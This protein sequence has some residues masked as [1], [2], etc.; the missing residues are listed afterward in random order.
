[1]SNSPIK[2]FLDSMKH[3]STYQ[4]QFIEMQMKSGQ[5]NSLGDFIERERE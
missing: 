5:T 2:N 1:M 3:Y 4:S